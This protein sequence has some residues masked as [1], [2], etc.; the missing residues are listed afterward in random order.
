[1]AYLK[2]KSLGNSLYIIIRMLKAIQDLANGLLEN[3]KGKLDKIS[4]A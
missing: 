1:M 2:L 3:C 4:V